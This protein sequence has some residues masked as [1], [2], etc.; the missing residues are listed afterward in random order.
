MLNK[1]KIFGNLG[2][3]VQDLKIFGKVVLK[4]DCVRLL[5]AINC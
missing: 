4:G 3:N 1:D 5:H 2:K